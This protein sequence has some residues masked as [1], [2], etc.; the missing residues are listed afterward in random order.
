MNIKYEIPLLLNLGDTI[1]E[2]GDLMNEI[3]ANLSTLGIENN[4]RAEGEIG[5]F[6]LSVNRELTK[7]EKEKMKDILQSTLKSTLPQYNIRVGE[8][9][10]N[11]G[12]VEQLAS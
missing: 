12:N 11:S 4:I 7:G 9:R 10:R 3:N 8:L 6:G 5:T 1:D 2:V